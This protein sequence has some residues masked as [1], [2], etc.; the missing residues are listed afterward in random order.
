MKEEQK[1]SP[2]VIE[3][4]SKGNQWCKGWEIKPENQKCATIQ[5]GVDDVNRRVQ[6]FAD[7]I[8]AVIEA[9][10]QDII[11]EVENQ[12]KQSFQQLGIQRNAIEQ[13]AQKIETWITKTETLFAG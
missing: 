13:Q 4:I 8:F 7:N 5:E 3:L 12:E 9:K 10:K 2:A 11:H 1:R 6:Q